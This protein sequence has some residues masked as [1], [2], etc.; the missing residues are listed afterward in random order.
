[1]SCSASTVT[2]LK[3][4]QFS[5]LRRSETCNFTR[6]CCCFFFLHILH[7]LTH[8][9]GAETVGHTKQTLTLVRPSIREANDNDH[10][11]WWGSDTLIS[12]MVNSEKQWTRKRGKKAWNNREIVQFLKRHQT[13]V[14]P[15]FMIIRTIS[16]ALY[17]DFTLTYSY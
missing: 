17:L 10:F 9:Y 4:D 12:P 7:V 16:A 11:S 1:M 6:C 14:T 8:V 5:L 13:C 15:V 2:P 3:F